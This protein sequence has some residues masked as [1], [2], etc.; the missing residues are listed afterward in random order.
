MAMILR[1][2]EVVQNLEQDN[3]QSKLRGRH[4][5]A[6]HKLHSEAPPGT[7]KQGME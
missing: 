3:T 2:V 4:T 6:V 7:H 1:P 5:D